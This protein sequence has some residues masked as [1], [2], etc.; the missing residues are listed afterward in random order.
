MKKLFDKIKLF[1]DT[2][3]I[4]LF[5]AALF[6]TNGAQMYVNSDPI[7][8]KDPLKAVHVAKSP[9]KPLKTIIIHKVDNGYCDK[10][11]KAE[12][13]KHFDSSRH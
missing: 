1:I 12:L 8:E 13:K 3:K 9:T 6:G 4:W 10:L 11:I 2:W 7:E 5:V